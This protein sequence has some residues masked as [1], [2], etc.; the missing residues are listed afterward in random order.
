MYLRSLPD[1]MASDWEIAQTAFSK[2]WKR[3]RAGHAAYIGHIGRACF[4]MPHLVGRID[5]K[6]QWDHGTYFLRDR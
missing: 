5:P 4:K 6:D 3:K 2:E 1:G